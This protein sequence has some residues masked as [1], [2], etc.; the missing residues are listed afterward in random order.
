MGTP[1]SAV[2]TRSIQWSQRRSSPSAYATS[3]T[4]TTRS[5]FCAAAS[6]STRSASGPS[7]VSPTKTTRRWSAAGTWSVAPPTSTAEPGARS[8]SASRCT[9]SRS[10]HGNPGVA[11]Q[12][13]V[14]PPAMPPARCT[15]AK[16]SW[17][18]A[19][20]TWGI[21]GSSP[22]NATTRGAATAMTTS[23]TASASQERRTPRGRPER[24]STFLLPGGAAQRGREGD[25]RERRREPEARGGAALLGRG[26]RGGGRRLRLHALGAERVQHGAVLRD[27]PRRDLLRRDGQQDELVPRVPLRAPAG[28]LRVE[29][30]GVERFA[31][32]P[33]VHVDDALPL[34]P[35]GAARRGRAVEERPRALVSMRVA[36]EHDIRAAGLKRGDEGGARRDVGAPVAQVGGVERPVEV[37]DR[38]GGGARRQRG[39]EERQLRLGARAGLQ[40]R[41]LV[42]GLGVQRD[43]ARGPIVERVERGGPGGGEARAVLRDLRG[44]HEWHVPAAVRLVVPHGGHHGHARGEGLHAREPLIPLGG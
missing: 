15:T 29:V 41:V 1:G 27:R 34:P 6:A 40:A 11:T 44:A 4:W 43:E 19:T 36:V 30:V 42:V 26:R 35:R 17:P 12:R 14:V 18:G 28:L 21:A 5:G 3:P 33:A 8:R 39:V 7:P 32:A 13:T 2:A 10:S 23:T 25:A 24:A 16:L 38:P 22:W 31:A 9:A 20:T 37:D